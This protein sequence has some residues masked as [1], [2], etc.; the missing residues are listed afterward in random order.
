MIVVVVVVVIVGVDILVTRKS[1]TN[2]LLVDLLTGMTPCPGRLIIFDLCLICE[3]KIF[4][5]A[6]FFTVTFLQLFLSYNFFYCNFFYPDA[7]LS[8]GV[9]HFAKWLLFR[10]K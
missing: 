4:F 10:G 8:V 7:H 2:L 9:D 3:F 6:E 5:L 1:L